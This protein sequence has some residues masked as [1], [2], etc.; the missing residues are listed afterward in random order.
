MV[1]KKNIYTFANRFRKG[2]S[3]ENPS[4]KRTADVAQL[5]RAADL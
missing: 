2:Q 3:T 1:G 4:S 5:A